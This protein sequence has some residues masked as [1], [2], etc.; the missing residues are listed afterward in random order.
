MAENFPNMW[1]KTNIQV[2]SRKYRVPNNMNP[3]RLTLRHIIIKMANVKYK[4]RILKASREK[5]SY[6]QGNSHKAIS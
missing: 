4:E 2:R 6:I 5:Q 1:K 3:K